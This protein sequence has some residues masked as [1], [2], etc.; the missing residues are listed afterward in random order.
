MAAAEGWKNYGLVKV[1]G[2]PA[3]TGP[4]AVGCLDLMHE[5]LLV[6]LYY[7]AEMESVANHDYGKL[8]F[9]G[10]YRKAY[11]DAY[12]MKFTGLISGTVNFLTGEL[13][14]CKN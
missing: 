5:G 11:M 4:Y 14:T 1:P 12:D 10:C 8:F 2:L 13:S 6:R 9:K 3:T 7:P